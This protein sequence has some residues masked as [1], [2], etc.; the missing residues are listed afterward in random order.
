MSSSI[1]SWTTSWTEGISG[2]R[3]GH[4]LQH[5]LIKI[6]LSCCNVMSAVP[7]HAIVGSRLPLPVFRSSHSFKMTEGR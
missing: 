2:G 1:H 3:Q 5:E 6:F 4:S 7:I